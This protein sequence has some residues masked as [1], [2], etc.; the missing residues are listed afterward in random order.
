MD[1]EWPNNHDWSCDCGECTDLWNQLEE[2]D[3]ITSEEH[4]EEL[5]QDLAQTFEIGGW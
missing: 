3:L 1:D 2:E 5:E 4:D